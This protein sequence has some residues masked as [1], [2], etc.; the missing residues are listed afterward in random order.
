MDES[1]RR[2]RHR[3]REKRSQTL[4]IVAVI[5]V[6]AVGGGALFALNQPR[7][8]LSSSTT[9]SSS[10]LTSISTPNS[11][12]TSSGLQSTT[13]GSSAS[14][15]TSSGQSSSG[16]ASSSSSSTTS[17]SKSTSSSTSTPNYAIGVVKSP[18]TGA[19][20]P[21]GAE[22]PTGPIFARFRVF[23]SGW[24]SPQYNAQQVIAMIAQLQ[25]NVLERMTTNTFNVDASV[26]V[27]SGC[28]SM[29]YGQF[30]NASMSAC[31]CYI[32]PRL[33]INATWPAGTFLSDAQQILSTPVV[34]RFQILSIDNWGSFCSQT[35]CTCALAKEIFQPLYAMGWKGVGVL[36]AGSPYHSTCG[37]AT[38]VDFDISG[39]SGTVPQA[40]LNSIKADKTVQKIL[41]YDPDF[42]GQAQAF[43]SECNPG[44][45][46]EVS[47]IQV[48]VS[49]QSSLGY[50]YVYPIE[51]TFWDANQIVTSA[52]GAYH[53]QTLYQIFQGWMKEYN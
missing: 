53:G 30:L 18:P 38:Y 23:D 49:Q 34:P 29:D 26:P 3:L 21:S 41:L 12:A 32:T 9:Q 22:Y 50:T 2:L 17:A 52:S 20:Y 25:P 44:C 42:P 15:S 47:S 7:T 11:T 24:T 31:K 6:A 35:S 39:N 14:S 1:R 37:W 40:L 48:A 4:V 43:M 10:N 13:S 36:N 51:Q 16:S 27:C 33:D 28:Q 8:A 19:N 45:D 5:V 46:S